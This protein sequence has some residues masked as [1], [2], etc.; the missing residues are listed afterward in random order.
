MPSRSTISAGAP[1]WARPADMPA[2]AE[3]FVQTCPHPGHLGDRFD[4]DRL[5]LP[6][7]QQGAVDVTL[8]VEFA[9]DTALAGRAEQDHRH[10]VADQ[11]VSPPPCPRRPASPPASR[12]AGHRRRMPASRT[13]GR[14]RPPHRVAREASAGRSLRRRTR[15]ATRGR[16]PRPTPDRRIRQRL[17]QGGDDR[18]PLS[19]GA[20]NFDACRDQVGGRRLLGDD[21]HRLV[22]HHRISVGRTRSSLVSGGPTCPT[23]RLWAIVL[24]ASRRRIREPLPRAGGPVTDIRS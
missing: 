20:D 24:I 12:W 14:G 18:R 13:G 1:V 6:A 3:T 22:G 19:G 15:L 21:S 23:L 9:V 17:G 5:G 2:R 4:H 8:T 11:R 7:D 10:V 16:P